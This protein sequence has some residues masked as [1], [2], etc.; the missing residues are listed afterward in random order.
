MAASTWMKTTASERRRKEKSKSDAS[1]K[2]N[3]NLT[4]QSINKEP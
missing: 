2:P 4:Q 3:S 1:K